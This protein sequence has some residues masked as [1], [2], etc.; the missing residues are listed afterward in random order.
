M[1]RG[2]VSRPSPPSLVAGLA[3]RRQAPRRPPAGRGG[4]RPPR[5]RAGTD[6]AALG[7]RERARALV[8]QRA[9]GTRSD[10]P[11]CGPRTRSPSLEPRRRERGDRRRLRVGARPRLD[12][13]APRRAP[14]A[15]ADATAR[16]RCRCAALAARPRVP[17][18]DPVHARRHRRDARGRRARPRRDHAGGGR[19]AVRADL[20]DTYERGSTRRFRARVAA[21]GR[22]FD[23]RLAEAAALARGYARIVA[24]E[25]PLAA[26]RRSVRAPG[27]RTGAARARRSE[28]ARR[29]RSAPSE[30]SSGSSKDSAPR[31]SPPPNRLGGPASST[32][33]SGSCRSSTTAESRAAASR[34]RSRSRRRSASATPPQPLSRTSPPRCSGSD[35]AATRE[36]TRILAP[37]QRTRCGRR[38]PRRRAGRARLGADRALARPDRRTLP[39]GVEG[40][41]RGRGLRRDRG[42]AR[43]ARERSR[44]RELEPC[45]AGAAG[46]VRDLRARPGATAPRHRTVAL[47]AHR[48]TV[49]V[50]RRRPRRPRPAREAEGRRR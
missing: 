44:G 3:G 14:G 46:G 29:R 39:R 32:A 23:V 47:P 7:D 30:R 33:S 11:R 8:E 2:A 50:R 12:G 18:A 31:R 40:G 43:P 34:S 28:A 16:R 27:R 21:A 35:A 26:G 4:G 13:A 10:R 42:L 1:R 25:L 38:R 5:P 49:L 37:R 36:L 20:L 22:G 24:A 48:R 9:A 19:T 6:R 45:G 41:G 15:V 17:R